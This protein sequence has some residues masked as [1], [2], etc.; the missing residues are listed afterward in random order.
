MDGL[1]AVTFLEELQAVVKKS[2]IAITAID[3]YFIY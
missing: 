2:R 1:A 3:K